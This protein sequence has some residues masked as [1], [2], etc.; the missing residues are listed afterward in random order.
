MVGQGEKYNAW[1]IPQREASR[2]KWL[3]KERNIMLG[4]ETPQREASRLKWLDKDRNI[5][6]LENTAKRSK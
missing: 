3:D 2:L 1:R 6:Y 4:E 5:I